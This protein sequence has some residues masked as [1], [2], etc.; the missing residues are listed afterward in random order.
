MIAVHDVPGQT[1]MLFSGRKLFQLIFPL[2][3]EQALAVFV[4]LLDSMMVSSVG[5]TAVS[6]VSLV[7][8]ISILLINIFSALATGGAVVVS[9]YIGANDK[10]HA[11]SA[12]EQLLLFTV[13]FSVAVSSLILIQRHPLLNILFGAVEPG[14]MNNCLIYLSI[15]APSYPFIALFNSASAIQIG[16]AHV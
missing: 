16:R 9:Q 1:P 3:I 11:K 4:G 6:G 2:I 10:A 7:D 12:S 14:I 13:L 5:E 15:T 8:M